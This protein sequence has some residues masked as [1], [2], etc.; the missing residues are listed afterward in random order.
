MNEFTTSQEFLLFT[1]ETVDSITEE[2][3]PYQIQENS[4]EQDSIFF[5]IGKDLMQIIDSK[6]GLVAV[7]EPNY[8]R[9]K[10]FQNLCSKS[11][12]HQIYWITQIFELEK[13]AWIFCLKKTA[14]F[15]LELYS[16]LFAQ[17]KLLLINTSLTL[18]NHP[19]IKKG[20]VENSLKNLQR[21]FYEIKETPL[22][23][24]LAL[25][26]GAGPSLKQS[27]HEI[28]KV[29]E[30]VYIFASLRSA[31]Y[32]VLNG[33]IPDFIGVIDPDEM[34]EI[35]QEIIKEIPWFFSL[36]ASKDQ[37]KECV[38]PIYIS[39]LSYDP[40]LQCLERKAGLNQ[41][42]I[43]GGHHVCSFLSSV[44]IQLGCSSIFLYGVDLCYQDQQKYFFQ[45]KTSSIG[46]LLQVQTNE[47][48][49]WT[50]LDFLLSKK[51]FEQLVL[52]FPQIAFYNRSNGLTI[53]GFSTF[54]KS[55]TFNMKKKVE[56]IENM[57]DVKNRLFA[58]K[59]QLQTVIFDFM[60]NIE[61]GFLFLSD[62]QDLDLLEDLQKS[63]AILSQSQMIKKDHEIF[64]YFEIIK[65]ME[66]RLL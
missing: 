10:T 5:G 49:K 34:I 62:L 43:D 13:L 25:I 59:K 37:I 16:D 12:F 66:N 2:W 36:A 32:L 56:I 19:F 9:I 4:S 15:C 14:Y 35:H 50:Q 63:F 18:S 24:Q 28:K 40:I 42:P 27:I 46:E 6:K 52:N 60:Q 21:T 54:C 38:Y 33:V 8:Q 22:K 3:T 55:S 61:N 48:I 45:Q 26:I 23:N 11:Q 64:Y 29:Q 1:L 53:E 44:A 39:L 30:S 41:I 47:G 20:I 31:E 7:F 58:L 17:F 65:E 57:S 51:W